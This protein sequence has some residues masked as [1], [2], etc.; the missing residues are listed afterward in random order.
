[1]NG[2][3][4]KELAKKP[5]DSEEN[6]W[7]RAEQVKTIYAHGLVAMLWTILFAVFLTF[8]LWPVI[9]HSI[10]IVW[11][12]S[13]FLVMLLRYLLTFAYRRA[14]D[15]SL[16]SR[17]WGDWFALGQAVNGMVWGSAGIWLFAEGSIA[18]QAFLVMWLSGL[19]AGALA[20]YS[21]MTKVFLAFTLPAMIPLTVQFFV[22]GSDIHITLGIAALI[23]VA[24][25]MVN[26]RR[27]N[28]IALSSLKLQYENRNLIA[29]LTAEKER[30][31]KLNED[32]QSKI[33]EHKQ[34]LAA[35]RES[36][37]RYRTVFEN[38]GTATII[39]EEDTTVSMAN[40]EY[41]KLT[42][43]SKEEVEGKQSWTEIVAKEDVEIMKE[44]H[45]KRREREA[46]PTEY[47][48][49]L[50]DRHGNIKNIWNKVSMI[51]GTRRSVASLMDI[52]SR[53]NAE[54]ALRASEGKYRSFMEAAPDPMIVYDMHGK[55]T[56]SNPA[57]ARVF[58]WSLDE[59]LG[60][61][62]DQFVPEE[63][64]PETSKMIEK[65]QAGEDF[66]GI[67]SQRYTKNGD[68]IPVSISG[69]TYQDHDEELAGSI[70]ILRDVTERKKME[71]AL[72]ESEARYR[73]VM[74][75]A[76]DPVVVYDMEGKVAYLN[77]AFTSVFGWTLEE[78][79]GKRPDFVP[80]ENMRE[81]RDAIERMLRGETIRSM[82][83]KRLTKDRRLV[84]IQVSSSTFMGP[85][86]Q[87]VGS[88]VI[89]RDVTERKKMEEALRESE[90]KYRLLMET[91]PDPVILYDPEGK[92]TY[93]NPAFEQTYG[94]TRAE[95]YGKRVDFV[96]PHEAE[97]TREVVERTVQGESLTTDTQ[98]LTKDGRVLDVQLKTAFFRGADEGTEYGMVIHRDITLL[99]QVEEELRKAK[100]A[101]EATNR[102]KSQFL[103]SMSHEIRTPMNAI[104]GMAD[105]LQE[106]PLNVEQQQ[107]VHVFRSAGENLLN[108]IDDILDISK[109]EAG[110][111]DLEDIDFDLGEVVE[112]TC[113]VLAIPAHAK[114]LELAFH[115]TPDVPTQLVGDPV[116]LRQIFINLMGN[117]IKF[118][119]AG[120]VVAAVKRART[121]PGEQGIGDVELIFSV[122]DTG[123]GIPPEK[124]NA[125]FDIFTQADS[126]TT[127]KHGGTGLGLT[128]SKRLVELMAGRIW[129]ESHVGEGSTF[130][131]TATFQVQ[132]EPKR[133]V[134]PSRVDLKGLRTL[135][136]DDNATNRLIL[137][138]ML[139][140]WGILVTEAEN[141]E[142]GLSELK[143][144]IVSGEP[145]KLLLLDCYMPGIDGFQVVETIRKEL[146]I[147]DITIMMLTSDSQSDDIVRCRELGVACYLVKPI[148]GSKLL[149]AI[150]TTI[151]KTRMVAE[152]PA[153]GRP[154]VPK[155]LRPLRI[156]LAEDSE[157]NRLLIK[158]Y[159]KKTPYQVEM[160]EDGEMAV[161]K[162]T[163]GTYDLVFMDM[164]MPVMDGYTATREIRK[165]E[166][167]EGVKATPI[168]ALTAYATK[169][170]EQKSLDAGCDAHLTK[171]IRKARLLE[172]ISKY[173]N[174]SQ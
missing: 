60:M 58:G 142:D 90:E 107:Y 147:A 84:N 7:L 22:Q 66:S 105:L 155:D 130:Y 25:M 145:Y 59:R 19:V 68:I 28:T 117:A 24:V 9:S 143:R 65:V 18:H 16:R 43:Y 85:N 73:S 163:S 8:I 89:L 41:E 46:A 29:F 120:E 137:K 40:A 55:V 104:I 27:V 78:S 118:T 93:I 121:A 109:V 57:F 83:T 111:L 62:M 162:F 140:G 5:Q 35:L 103:A 161:E 96:P 6:Q 71:E 3:K 169:E 152:E 153:E 48:F 172:A 38:T 63:N 171:P 51:P 80:E 37:E 76:P 87:P 14:P 101:A 42:G 151:G 106:T 126:S 20:M 173:T 97:R 34:T 95:L 4:K 154:A 15:E 79:L 33:E 67:E 44:Y 149:D 113:E 102:F 82:E 91:S 150:T 148:K 165:W 64:W 21:V 156:L 135:V 72:R 81:T 52:T 77:P 2:K 124:V 146:N 133:Y 174:T 32:L 168:I 125:I 170:E 127:R 10:L 136:V 131:F 86:G 167:A 30:G 108:I 50:V 159:L 88:I 49:R 115:V 54:E 23:F 39:V 26:A 164:Q 100:E 47:E 144:A 139:S 94:W 11:F 134:H 99:K 1:M 92:T 132:A 13:V 114:G 31:D 75:A 129:V 160:A 123:I 166:S 53:K 17:P 36:E 128:I 69:S 157:D 138:Q 141:G 158:S 45:L 122:A 74:E 119:E 61:K 112:Q 116:R 98:R 110:H 12:S 56:Y 70:V